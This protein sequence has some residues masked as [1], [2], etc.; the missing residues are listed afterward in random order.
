MT[1]HGD[2]YRFEPPPHVTAAPSPRSASLPPAARTRFVGRET[3]LLAIEQRLAEGA[4]LV[5]LVG[6]G[7]VGKTRSARELERRRAARGEPTLFV[8]LAEARSLED[9]L[10]ALATAL[11]VPL[12]G[13]DP[14]LRSWRAAA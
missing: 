6:P 14:A 5:T 3:E 2:G 13:A 11:D 8:D 1:V 10:R 12:D 9:A 4:R 7:G